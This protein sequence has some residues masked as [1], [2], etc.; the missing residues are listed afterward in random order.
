MDPNLRQRCD[1][2]FER[3][4]RAARRRVLVHGLVAWL[5]AAGAVGLAQL[6]V[7]G[8]ADPPRVV[9]LGVVL[10]GAVILLLL[11]GALVGR[12]WSALR[13]RADL[14]RRLD[15]A[16]DYADTLAAAEEALRM[17]DRWRADTPVRATLV[18]RLLGRAARVLDELPLWRLLPVERPALVF[19]LL[20]AV[21]GAGGWFA[22]AEP[23]ALDRGA[24]R[25]GDPWARVE[26]ARAG[27]LRLVPGPGH[28]VAG[29]TLAV[30]SLDLIGGPDPVVCEVRAGTGLWHPLMARRV[31]QP[32]GDPVLGA[33]FLRWETVL[34]DIRED[35]R[36]RFRAGDRVSEERAIEV[37][38]PPLLVDL[39]A[40]VQ[41]PAYTGLR[42]QGLSRLPA[43][44]EAPAGSR[45]SLAGRASRPLRAAAAVSEGADTLALAVRGDTLAGDLPLTGPRRFRLALEDERGLAGQSELMYEVAVIPDRIP[46]ARLVRPEDD[47]RLPL[48]APLYLQAGAD[49]DY[50]LAGVDL[51]LRRGDADGGAWTAG[52]PGDGAVDADG[53]GWERL[54]LVA[55][56]AASPA[57]RRE[58]ATSL[59]PLP[60]AVAPR[61]ATDGAGLR[62][63]LD[64]AAGGLAL[65][66]GD[67][68]ELMLEARDNRRPGPAGVGRSA[69]LRLEV[70]S[71]L[72]LLENL[73]ADETERRGDLAEVR[74]RTESLNA[75][76][77]RLR[78]ELLKDPAPDW[79][80]QQ[81]IQAAI[82]R[83]RELQAELSRLAEAMQQDLESL[84][85]NRLTS[86]ELMEKMDRIAE[87][88]KEARSDEL[89]QMLEK[90]RETLAQMSAKELQL[91]MDELN[92]NQL[93]M[94]RRL[95]TAMDMLRD[96]AREQEME[97]LANLVAEMI[98]KQQELTEASRNADPAAES[99]RDP[100]DGREGS[101][102]NGAERKDT[103]AAQPDAEEL[104]RRQ[105][106]VR[107]E[108][109]ALEKRLQEALDELQAGQDA[110]EGQQEEPTA[111]EQEM[112]EALAEALEQL[113][114]QQTGQ[115]MDQAGQKLQQ[116]LSQEATEQMQ[117]ALNDLAGLYHVLLRSQVAMQMAMQAE[118]S[119]QMRDLAADLLT[120]SD[121]Q[122]RL[123]LDL[124]TTLHDVRADDLARR[125]HEILQGAI[126]VREGLEAVAG[127][128]PREILRMLDQLDE[129]LA[130]IGRALDQ[131]EE[132]RAPNARQASEHTLSEM[133]RLVI[134]ILT[135]AQMTGQGGGS[136]S[137]QM[138]LSQQLQQMAQEQSGLNALA[139]QMRQQQGRLSEE[140]R[141]GMQRLQQGQQGLAGRA[142]ELAEE[143]RLQQQQDGDRLLGDLDELTRDMER[144]GDDLGGGLVTEETLRR[145]DRIL[146][147]LLD[148]HNA[149]R[150]R[151]WARRRESRTADELYAGQDGRARDLLDELQPEARRWRPVEE[152][153]PAYRDLVREY[154]REIQLLH[155]STGRATDGGRGAAGGRP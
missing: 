53:S 128:A 90:L 108:L 110:Q 98:S 36:Y 145:Q 113:N 103:P 50:G 33:P 72:E 28:V 14:A 127:A 51:L 62:L 8:F 139:E 21:V 92:R 52:L 112:Q 68:L 57:G 151:D 12:P 79:D 22:L 131:L 82:E 23:E 141:S 154:F 107:R 69:V 13:R 83:Q 24:R 78:R 4:H 20:A 89:E 11:A 45:L 114:Q 118:Q 109:D 75:D 38:H 70:P 74:R 47:G 34:E 85:E 19:A 5:A 100:Q 60:L 7:L 129:L 93:E 43:Y 95:D 88:M 31:P 111:A 155:E 134:G 152:A 63:D 30:A 86:P 149:S 117:Q 77:E 143:Q 25:L 35:L 58:H 15:R 44:L 29:T 133:N 140:F 91:S 59:G 16:G 106:A 49:D 67:V 27:T 42:A 121:R 9:R 80:R 101:E 147:R 61:E 41:P 37:W 146:S 26:P 66:P 153:P 132:G 125:Q 81:E 148:M 104:A 96:L 65:V 138:M 123:G 142:R 6:A 48:S 94:L 105:D 87:L 97:G 144:V 137:S 99:E 56:G 135:Q 73:D 1:A 54:P 124:P 84:A 2:R 130:G 39:A 71:S 10:S 3:L 116:Q 40:R 115:K 76:L 126:A 32:G 150:E 136:S 119:G 64:L 120:L 55:G 18:E 46:V 122:E 17:P 102:E